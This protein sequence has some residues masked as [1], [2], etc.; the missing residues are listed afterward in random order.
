MIL[1]SLITFDT[2]TILSF[3][4]HLP[5]TFDTLQKSQT[6]IGGFFNFADSES[7][8]LARHHQCKMSLILVF[9]YLL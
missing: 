9:L 6:N 2:F 8:E 3:I 7:P 4:L 5:T 1:Y